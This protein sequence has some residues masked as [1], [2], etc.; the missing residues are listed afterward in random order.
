[1]GVTS[2]ALRDNRKIE[3]EDSRRKKRGKN[4]QR[5]K[6]RVGSFDGELE[7]EGRG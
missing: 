1:V 5:K 4:I 6:R 2:R 7:K 3:R